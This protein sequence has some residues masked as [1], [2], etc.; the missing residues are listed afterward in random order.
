[1]NPNII[2]IE[3]V[4]L[5]ICSVIDIK[6]FNKEKG[7]IPSFLTTAFIF[8]V[9]FWSGLVGAWYG[10]LAGVFALFLVDI[11][12]FK[13]IPDIKILIAIGMSFVDVIPFLIFLAI[14][15]VFGAITQFSAIKFAKVSKDKGEIPYIPIMT[16]A[17]FVSIGIMMI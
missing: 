4:F 3:A 17:Y 11:G 8:V 7:G 1:M 12:L 9:L 2:L 15:L 6:T 14:M 16:L 13:G 5:L 10:L